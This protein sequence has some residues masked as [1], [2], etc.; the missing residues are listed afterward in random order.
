MSTNS[1]LSLIRIFAW[2]SNPDLGFA[3]LKKNVSQ[4]HRLRLTSEAAILSY[5]FSSYA[6]SLFFQTKHCVPPLK[7]WWR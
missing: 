4:A 7:K 6:Y 2:E 1:H 5:G 3:E